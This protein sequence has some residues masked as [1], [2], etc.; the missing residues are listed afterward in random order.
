MWKL[1][2]QLCPIIWALEAVFVPRT[3]AD[4]HWTLKK[5]KQYIKSYKFVVKMQQ[6]MVWLNVY[7]AFHIALEVMYAY[8]RTVE[9]SFNQ[10]AD[11]SLKCNFE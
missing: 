7:M 4:Q 3:S 10:E 1:L 5:L 8:Y 2:K 9:L 6:Y 11:S